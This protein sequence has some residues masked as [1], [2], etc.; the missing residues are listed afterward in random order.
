MGGISTDRAVEKEQQ[1]GQDSGTV[2]EGLTPA[3]R[4]CLHFSGAMALHC[5]GQRNNTLGGYS[6]RQSGYG[7]GVNFSGFLCG[8]RESEEKC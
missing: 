8:S 6:P 4:R 1:R 2:R 5:C 7:P 3:G